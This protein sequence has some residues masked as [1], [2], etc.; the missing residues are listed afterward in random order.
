MKGFVL[1]TGATSGIGLELSKIYGDNNYNLIL[2]GR[3][4]EKLLKFKNEFKN[5]K[6]YIYPLDLSVMENVDYLLKEIDNQQFKID[7]LINN[8]G[9][10]FNGEFT[11]ISWHKHENIIDLNIKSL[12]KLTYGILGF[13]KVQGSGKIL[14]VASTG[15]YQPGPLIGVYYATKAYVLSFSSALREEL[16]GSG[17]VVSTL[18][19]GATKTDFSK[20]AGKEDLS[21]AMSAKTVAEI[22][23]K[24]LK[25]NRAII[26]PGKMNKFLVFISKLTPTIINAKVV[27]KIQ[28][29]AINKF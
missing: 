17:I 14:N 27:K 28:G 13:M 5:I 23:Y 24:G 21:V 29:K 22:A 12:T 3:N 11:E 1:I 4:K 10:G 6:V 16:S 19:P 15:S 18:C 25:K 8:A 26:I 9:A 7:I 20:R 2:V